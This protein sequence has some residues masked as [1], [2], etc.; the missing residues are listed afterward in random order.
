M[1]LQEY[2]GSNILPA[3]VAGAEVARTHLCTRYEH[4]AF[5]ALA[6]VE[7]LDGEAIAEHVVHWPDG[8]KIDVRACERCQTPIARLSRQV[9]TG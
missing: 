6:L 9:E 3:S 4:A 1:I 5:L 7:R 2:L 8:T